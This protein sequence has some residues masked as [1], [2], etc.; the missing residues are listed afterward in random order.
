MRRHG[1][2]SFSLVDLSN[3]G[4]GG[5]S[6]AQ[7]VEDPEDPDSGSGL[8]FFFFFFREAPLS[9]SDSEAAARADGSSRLGAP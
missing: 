7:P 1:G 2:G 9:V 5:P 3:L 4:G 8:L 6:A